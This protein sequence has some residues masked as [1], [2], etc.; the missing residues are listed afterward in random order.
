VKSRSEGRSRADIE[1]DLRTEFDRVGIPQTPEQV[2]GYAQMISGDWLGMLRSAVRAATGAATPAGSRG[3]R[4]RVT[5]ERWVD[6]EVSTDPAARTAVRDYQLAY[7]VFASLRPSGLAGNIVS[8]RLAM[9]SVGNESRVGV[10]LGSRFVG[11]LLGAAGDAIAPTVVDAD[12][13]D[14]KVTVSARIDGTADL[15]RMSVALP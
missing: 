4:L 11:T 10:F 14:Q 3:G 15:C 7:D 13:R 12:G 8:A 2:A 6:V 1:A 5:G 9:I